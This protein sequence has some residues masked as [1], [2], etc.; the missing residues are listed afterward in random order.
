[1]DTSQL[2]DLVLE[3]RHLPGQVQQFGALVGVLQDGH[4]R[5]DAV[6]GPVSVQAVFQGVHRLA[7]GLLQPGD[8]A[9]DHLE[10]GLAVG[11]EEGG[12]ILLRKPRT[13]VAN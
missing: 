10:A 1:V 8:A 2:L 11:G 4:R 9:L 5:P 6:A 12:R 3:L 13:M 7:A